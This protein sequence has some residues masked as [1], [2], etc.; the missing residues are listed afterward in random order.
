MALPVTTRWL[1]SYYFVR[2]GVAAAWV[3]AAFTAGRS[4]P[5]IAAILLIAAAPQDER[6][7]LG[8]SLM[9]G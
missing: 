6:D 8:R 3:A 5:L 9:A 4:M 7:W 1:T 2:A